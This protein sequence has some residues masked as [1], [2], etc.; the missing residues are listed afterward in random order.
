[1]L[2]RKKGEDEDKSEVASVLSPELLEKIR[3]W[4]HTDVFPGWNP[5]TVLTETLS[6]CGRPAYLEACR[7]ML[8]AMRQRFRTKPS[9]SVLVG[10]YSDPRYG[11]MLS[12]S[13]SPRK[14][15]DCIQSDGGP[16]HPVRDG[17][18]ILTWRED[19]GFGT[20]AALHAT[21]ESHKNAKARA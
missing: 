10:V 5:V 21:K 13:P 8:L 2:F 6:S 18:E 20:E 1:M 9:Y 12:L 3:Q 15:E 7:E 14:G 16:L 17:T 19:V 11:R 4:R